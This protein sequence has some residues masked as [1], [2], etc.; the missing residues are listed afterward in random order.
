MAQSVG[1]SLSARTLS[2][3]GG[4]SKHRSIVF[5]LRVYVDRRFGVVQVQPI[6]HG[7]LWVSCVAVDADFGM[8]PRVV[9]RLGENFR[10]NLAVVPL[11][12]DC[13]VSRAEQR[14]GAALASSKH[15]R[16]IAS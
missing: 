6:E 2:R 4:L 12:S 10:A 7:Q 5:S 14:V 11:R 3:I 13:P 16:A 1:D 8:W 9:V 15:A